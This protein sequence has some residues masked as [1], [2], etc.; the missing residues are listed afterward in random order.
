MPLVFMNLSDDPPWSRMRA[1]GSSEPCDAEICMATRVIAGTI[2]EMIFLEF[3]AISR[4][5]VQ[6]H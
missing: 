2:D 5:W 4:L 1:A 6:V 3:A